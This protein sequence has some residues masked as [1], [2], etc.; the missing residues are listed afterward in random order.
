MH[1][2][3]LEF[4]SGSTVVLLGPNGAG[5]TTMLRLLG[6]FLDPS[7]G[8]VLFNGQLMQ[9]YSITE[10]SKSLAVLTQQNS[11]DFPFTAREVVSMGRIPYGVTRHRDQAV[12]TVIDRL[13]V[14][15]DRVYTTLSGGERQLVH[16]ARVLAQTWG[17]GEDACL[18]LDEPTASLDLRHQQLVTTLLRELAASG[19]L[20]VIVMHDINLAAKVAGEL[21]LLSAGEIIAAG[22][23]DDILN[24]ANLQATFGVNMQ[25]IVDT[26]TGRKFFTSEE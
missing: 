2:L 26:S 9:T 10:R 14:D 4:E 12:E 23:R 13:G 5:K 24:V 16:V 3:N 25:M 1:Q 22:S 6:G 18:L 17:R 19:L 20:E 15:G 7:A 11:L 8:E 21:V